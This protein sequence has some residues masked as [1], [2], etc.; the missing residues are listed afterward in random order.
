VHKA[1][2]GST[3][4]PPSKNNENTEKNENSSKLLEHPFAEEFLEMGWFFQDLLHGLPR[5][6]T[7]I[8]EHICF[9][10]FFSFFTLLVVGSVRQ[11][12]LTHVVFRAHVKIASRIV[13][14]RRL[15]DTWSFR[16][17]GC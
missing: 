13:S 10:L 2:A 15:P 6:F 4:P 14:Y 17:R 11:I 3:C 12:K 9:L 16:C 5:L 8:S 7:V 1:G